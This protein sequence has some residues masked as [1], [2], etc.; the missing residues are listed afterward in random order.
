MTTNFNYYLT[1]TGW[2]EVFFTNDKQNIRFDFSYL[3]DPLSDLIEG[4]CRLINN[5][6]DIEKIIFAE[7]PGEH[8]LIISKQDKD[9]VKIEIFWSDEWEEISKAYQTTS[10]KEL[11]YSDI[12]ILANFI[13]VVCFGID[14]LLDRLSLAEYK[15]KWHL[16]EFP[17]DSYKQLKQLLNR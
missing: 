6:S 14:S 12:N 16:F 4:L 5:Q 7:E 15:E 9:T 13:S 11:I 1:G 17:V 8:S 2:A 3:S 10:R